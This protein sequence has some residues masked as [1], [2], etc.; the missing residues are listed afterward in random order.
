[1]CYILIFRIISNIRFMIIIIF[2]ILFFITNIVMKNEIRIN[3]YL[4]ETGI[5]SRRKADQAI[6]QGEVRING[7]VAQLGDQVS[8]NDVIRARTY[9]M[10]AVA[11]FLMDGK[12][13]NLKTMDELRALVNDI[14]FGNSKGKGK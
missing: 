4:S 1:M 9:L 8:E 2:R 12:L 10:T 7:V 5:L 6:E 3:K 14:K 13:S 11:M